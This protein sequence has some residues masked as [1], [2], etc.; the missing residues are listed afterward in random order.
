MNLAN[1]E[2]EFKCPKC[3]TNLFTEWANNGFGTYAVQ[4]SPYVCECGWSEKG[5]D[6]CI[7]DK[8]FSWDKCKGV[9]VV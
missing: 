8:C 5:C 2:P 7:K 3:E 1:K 9:A 6:K 4:S